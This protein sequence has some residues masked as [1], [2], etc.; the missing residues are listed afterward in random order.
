LEHALRHGLPLSTE[1]AFELAVS[2]DVE[3][4][5]KVRK[6][7]CTWDWRCRDATV[8]HNDQRMLVYLENHE[9]PVKFTAR[10]HCA[11]VMINMDVLCLDTKYFDM[12]RRQQYFLTDYWHIRGFQLRTNASILCTWDDVPNYEENKLVRQVLEHVHA[13]LLRRKCYNSAAAVQQVRERA[14]MLAWN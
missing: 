9:A 12:T 8:K 3:L 14:E 10:N 5:D 6:R 13:A 2:G 1:L 11:E 7:G 4:L